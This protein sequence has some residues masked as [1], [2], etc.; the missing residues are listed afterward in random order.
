[1]CTRHMTWSIG[2]KSCSDLQDENSSICIHNK[3]MTHRVLQIDNQTWLIW[4]ERA[5][6]SPA[7]PVKKQLETSI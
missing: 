7:A 3:R 4:S 5:L 1:M 6:K 2:S